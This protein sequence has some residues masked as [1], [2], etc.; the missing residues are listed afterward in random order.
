[1]HIEQCQLI[2]ARQATSPIAPGG[3]DQVTHIA[4]Q[5]NL[6]DCTPSSATDQARLVL[7]HLASVNIEHC[8]DTG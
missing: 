2:E 7:V 6:R 3:D 8:E 1:M 4:F 5:L